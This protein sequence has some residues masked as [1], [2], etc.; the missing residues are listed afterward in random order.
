MNCA[1][2]G[3]AMVKPLEPAELRWRCP[4]TLVPD[5][6][7]R[8]PPAPATVGQ[9]RAIDALKVGLS[10]RLPGFNIYVSGR[11]GTGRTTAVRRFLESLTPDLCPL[12][13]DRIYVHNFREPIAPRLLV[14]PAGKGREFAREMSR[15]IERLRREIPELLEDPVHKAAFEEIRGRHEQEQQDSI[16]AFEKALEKRDFSLVKVRVGPTVL[17]EIFPNVGG[18]PVDWDTLERGVSDGTF[19][20]DTLL[21]LRREAEPLREQ[22]GALL[23]QLQDIGQR[24]DEQV[25]ARE[26]SIV[27]NF[28]RPLFD[29]IRKKFPHEGVADYVG[30][31]QEDILDHVDLFRVRGAVRSEGGEERGEEESAF[32]LQMGGNGVDQD[33]FARYAMNLLLDNHRR[34]GCPVVFEERPTYANLVGSIPVQLEKGALRA[35]FLQI[36]AGSIL[37]ADGG[38]LV[39]RA[40]DVLTAPG[41]WEALKRVL[42]TGKLEIV[43]PESPLFPGRV[44]L[45][46]DPIPVDVK[47]I[48][49]GEPDLHDLLWQFDPDFRKIFKIKSEFDTEMKLSAESVR[50]FLGVLAEVCKGDL[51][52]SKDGMQAL[53]EEGVRRAGRRGWISCRFNSMADLIREGSY[54]ARAE[55][56]KAVRASHLARAVREMERRHALVHEKLLDRLREQVIRIELQGERIGQVNGLSVYDLGTIAFG[57]PSRITASVSPGKSGI[58]NIEREAGLSGRIH[59]KAVLILSGFLRGRYARDFPLGLSASLTFEQSY[60]GIEG[61]SATCAEIY[62]LLSSLSGIPIR[63]SI[64]VTGSADQKGNVQAVGGVNEKVEGFFEAFR[65][66]GIQSPAGVL[67][68]ASNVNDLMLKEEVVQAAAEGKFQIW[69][70]QHVDE[71][72]EILTGHSAE[73]VNRRVTDTLSHFAE[74]LRRFDRL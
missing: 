68:P 71:G 6:F 26:R 14:L 12:L 74:T 25:R 51:P 57:I 8:I 59:D 18:K 69:P 3:G 43:A 38:F 9:D 2:W 16:R 44:T 34:A 35:D 46:P 49:I 20:R 32:L 65:A 52:L 63:Q 47:V 56:E 73:E 5:S 28:V 61:D 50:H 24:A 30:D 60:G 23:R 21:R 36:K 7:D 55:G 64:A 45:K 19:D 58:I 72:I 11:P 10:L 70:I 22:L 40:R 17:P 62:A 31:V 67:L 39:L 41:A 13:K 53:V 66:A 4:E 37:R 1:G 42:D 54:W 48:L 29:R 27:E 15:L 33:P